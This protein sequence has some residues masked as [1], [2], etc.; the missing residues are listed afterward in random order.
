MGGRAF[1]VTMVKI[2]RINLVKDGLEKF[3]SPNEG[4]ILEYIWDHPKTSSSEIQEHM[5]D[6]S[7]ACVAGTLDRLVK[8][9]FVDRKLDENSSR[10]KYQ[11]FPALTREEV[12]EK[13]TER[14]LESLV[15]TFGVAVTDNLDVLA[16]RVKKQKGKGK[17]KKGS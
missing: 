17:R 6:L 9:G 13:L 4:R 3:F 2:T 5:S 15:D 7:L 12:G 8:S 14:V 11:Y 10:L 1:P 16:K